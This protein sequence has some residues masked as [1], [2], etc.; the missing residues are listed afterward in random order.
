MGD[1]NEVRETGERFGSIFNKMQADFFNEFIVNNS[2]IDIPLGGFNFTWTDKWG[3]K[4]S[5]LDWFLILESFYEVFLTLMVSS[6]RKMEDFHDLVSDTWNNDE[7][8]E[9]NGLTSF[10]LQNLKQVIREWVA[11]K[12]SA[13]YKLKKYL[14]EQLYSIDTKLA[15]RGIL[16]DGDWIEDLMLVKDEFLAHF[17]N[18]FNRSTRMSLSLEVDLIN[19]LSSSQSDFL[20]HQVSH[21][22]IKRAV[23][24]CR[25][26]L[27]IR[28]D[29]LDLV[30]EKIGF[31]LK[32]RS[33]IH[34]C[35]CNA[36]SS[37][38][39]N[40]SPTTEFELFR[41]I[42]Q[43]D[44]LSL[45]LFI[46]AMEGL[47]ALTCKAKELGLF[48][49]ATFGHDNISISHLKYAD[50]VIFFG[51]W[52]STN[53]NNLIC[54]LRCFFLM[55]GFKFN[56]HKSNVLGVCVSDEEVSDM[57]NV[58]GCG[59]TKLPF[60]YLG[61]P[62]GCNMARSVLGNL[63][64]YYMS[65]YM[66]PIFVQKKLESMR[67]KFFIGGDQDEKKITWVKWKKCLASKKLGG[68]GIGTMF[69]NMDQLEKQLDNK[70]F[71]ET[72]SM[73]AF[74]IREFRDTL[75]QH[76]ESVKNLIDKR[77]L[78]KR[79]YDRR[80]NERQMQTT[81][82]EVD[83]SK[84]LDASL[85]D[86]ESSEIESREYDTS[87]RSGNDSHANDAD[88]KPI[89]DEEPMAEIQLTVENNVFAIGQQHTEQPEFNNEGEVNQDA[90]QC[91]DKR[92]LP[93]KLTDNQITKLS[94]QSLE[95]KNTCLKKIV[96]QF[97][98]DFLRMKAHC[99]NLELKYQN[100]DLKEGKHG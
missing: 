46:L 18:C 92:P 88:I 70:E 34:G 20:E 80:V 4:M 16:K 12:K 44:P 11:L 53:A 98:K 33:W 60:K 78:H 52:S 30:M 94:Y 82:E 93:T 50:D 19:H 61:V 73:A 89:Y 58:I 36:R 17:R 39:V 41:G 96:T 14:Q 99:V 65:I 22:E 81:E 1:F 51:E 49:G 57:A 97:Q 54:M 59:V 13:T 24:D 26:V 100:Q 90:E 38:L 32:W 35:L 3:T 62:V 2:L 7:I 83:A 71:Q 15:I 8:V 6:L 95:S 69:L 48:K 45:F 25:G 87:S 63:Q 21:D 76:M 91:H 75:I 77:T 29:F 43:G 74:Q 56:V 10:K 28:W 5:K 86:T 84:A 66:M 68:L 64:T 47:H 40:G 31:G 27:P 72:G 67:N 55:S 79:E 85:V 9:V 37:V 23:W 42:R